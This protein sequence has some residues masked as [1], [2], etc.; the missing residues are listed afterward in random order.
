MRA[1][2]TIFILFF[3]IAL[4]DAIRGGHWL[5]VAFWLAVGA[6][7][8]IADRRELARRVPPPQA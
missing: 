3:G 8:F 2:L 6:L 7:F 1:N 4:L 5:R